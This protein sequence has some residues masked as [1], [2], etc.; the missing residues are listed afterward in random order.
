MSCA[1]AATLR[2]TDA[3]R[4]RQPRVYVLFACR[5]GRDR[6][7]P[8]VLFVVAAGNGGDDGIGD[9]ADRSPEYPCAYPLVNI[10]CVAST[11]RRDQLSAFSNYGAR[12]V[13]LAAPGTGSS[14]PGLARSYF[15]LSGTSMATPHVAGAAALLLAERPDLGV[16]ELRA[17]LLGEWTGRPR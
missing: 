4:Q 1:P 13:D 3:D 11:N 9:D 14:V 16:S 2:G 5:A 8:S 10:V 6:R 15:Y 17:A 7:G 12:S